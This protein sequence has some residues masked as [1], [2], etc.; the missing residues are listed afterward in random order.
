[1]LEMFTTI[2]KVAGNGVNYLRVPMVYAGRSVMA[3]LDLEL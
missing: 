1:M 2:R 3:R